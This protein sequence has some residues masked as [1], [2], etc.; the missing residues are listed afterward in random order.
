MRDRMIA[1]SELVIR[2]PAAQDVENEMDVL[3]RR[4]LLLVSSRA[5]HG[6]I[7]DGIKCS[8]QIGS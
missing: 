7:S 4:W 3:I 5:S 6:M 8:G 2:V 1:E